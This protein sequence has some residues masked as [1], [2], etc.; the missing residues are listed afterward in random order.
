MKIPLGKQIHLEI[1]TEDEENTN[2]ALV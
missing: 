1:P 2:S